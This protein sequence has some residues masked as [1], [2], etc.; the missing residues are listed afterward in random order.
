[1]VMKFYQR[2]IVCVLLLLFSIAKSNEPVAETEEPTLD[3]Y[4]QVGQ[5]L[6]DAFAPPEIKAQFE[7]PTPQQWMEFANRFQNALQGDSLEDLIVYEP[8]ARAALI[9]LRAMEGYED[10]AEW[11]EER[12]DYI[13][14]AKQVTPVAPRPPAVQPKKQL[15]EEIPHLELWRDRMHTRAVPSRAAK[16]VPKLRAIFADEG[17]PPDLVWLAEAESSF[18]PKARSP[19]GARGLFQ[20]MPATAKEMG[21]RTFLPDERENPEKSARAAARYLRQLYQRFESWPLA[22]AAYNAGGGRV[23][24]TLNT[25][26][27][28]TF[29]E[30]S[31]ALPAETR[32]YVPK[33][34]ATMEARAGTSWL[35]LPAP[36]G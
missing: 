22:L 7:F 26:R 19:V 14:A 6:F 34:L 3:D 13:D 4:Y 11:L 32:M 5:A 36:R 17:M 21:L 35:K 28:T 31:D 25:Q 20:F 24:R 33:V 9:A 15:A 30:I 16:L 2:G 10:Y 8:E 12:L 29:A 23:N 18:N 1:M 27:A